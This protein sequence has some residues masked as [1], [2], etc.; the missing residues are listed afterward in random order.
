MSFQTADKAKG[1]TLLSTGIRPLDSLL[2]GGLELGLTYLFYGDRIIRD[3]LLRIMVHAQLPPERG[4]FNSPTIIIDSENMVNI[5][6][7]SHHSFELDLQPEDVMDNI[8]VSRA[9]NSSQTYDLVMNQLDSF[10]ERIPAKLLLLPGMADIFYGE[11]ADAEK[12]QQLTH[13]A[14]RVMTFSLRHGVVS[15][16]TGSSSPKYKLYP[17]AGQTIKHCAQIHVYVEETPQRVIYQLTKHPQHPL[18]EEQEVKLGLDRIVAAT[19]PL[20]FF[21]DG[22]EE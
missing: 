2:N 22:E 20:S 16:I 9:F 1:P 12:K 17:T 13:M 15:I 18:R 7:I 8:F 14:H 10:F 21:I 4:G 5:Q 11:R 3:I 6:Q 19:L